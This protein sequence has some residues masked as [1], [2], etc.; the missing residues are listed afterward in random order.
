MDQTWQTRSVTRLVHSGYR[1]VHHGGPDNWDILYFL[2]RSDRDERYTV[3]HRLFA[4]RVGKHALTASL[5][6]L[7]KPKVGPS[8][9]N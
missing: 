4:F 2:L 1:M 6:S 3:G 9:N 5:K 7:K 8:A